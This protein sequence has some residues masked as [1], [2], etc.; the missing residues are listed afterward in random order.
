MN[1]TDESDATYGDGCI[2]EKGFGRVAAVDDLNE[3]LDEQT[4][5]LAHLG[6][7]LDGDLADGPDRV[8]AYAYVLRVKVHTQ[9][10]HEVILNSTHLNIRTN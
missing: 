4:N 10:L 9:D 7:V 6:S 5:V 8:V 3:R 1:R 2:L